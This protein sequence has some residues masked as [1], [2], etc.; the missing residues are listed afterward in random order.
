MFYLTK[1]ENARMPVPEPEYHDVGSADIT[2]GATLALSSGKLVANNTAPTHIAAADYVK[3]ATKVPVYRITKDMLFEVPCSTS[4]SAFAAGAKLAIASGGLEV[5]AASES[6]VV[7][8]VDTLGAKSVGDT[9]I[10][11]F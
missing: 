3:G 11:R 7:T 1:I 4:P 8:I 6:G 10:V 2:A 5:G 9:I